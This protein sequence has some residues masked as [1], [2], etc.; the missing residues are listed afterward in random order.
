MDAHLLAIALSNKGRL[1][2]F[3]KGIIGLVPEGIAENEAVI[4]L[5]R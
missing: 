2:T 5:S 1:A 3:D 4:I